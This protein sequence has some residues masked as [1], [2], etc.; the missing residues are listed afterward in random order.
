MTKAPHPGVYISE[1]MDARG[2]SVQELACRSRLSGDD[3]GEIIECSMRITPPTAYAL[4]RAFD[5]PAQL[6]I[7][8]QDAHDLMT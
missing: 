1:E 2:W 8:L 5:V 4:A 6:F 7:G 3:I